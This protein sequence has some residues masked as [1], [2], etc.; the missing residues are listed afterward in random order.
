[1]TGRLLFDG[2]AALWRE[3][4]CSLTG[5]LLFDVKAS[6]WRDG[7]EWRG[8]RSETMKKRRAGRAN[9]HRPCLPAAYLSAPWTKSLPS[10]SRTAG[11]V[12]T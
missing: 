11:H 12:I 8:G 3:E 10:P 4:G 5:K 7:C 9:L 6:L 2:K 1:L